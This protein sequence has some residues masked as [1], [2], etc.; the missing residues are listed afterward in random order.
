MLRAAPPLAFHGIEGA[1]LVARGTP[2]LV[3]GKH[4]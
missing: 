3:A 1:P 2:D 4:R